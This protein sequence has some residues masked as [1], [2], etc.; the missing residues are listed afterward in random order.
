[1]QSKGNRC[2]LFTV[3]ILILGMGMNSFAQTTETAELQ[4]VIEQLEKQYNVRFSYVPKQLSGIAVLIPSNELDLA[5]AIKSL[6]QQTSLT[7]KKIDDR[8][9]SI[10]ENDPKAGSICGLLLNQWTGLPLEGAQIFVGENLYATISDA[11]GRFFIPKKFSS[12]IIQ[13][14]FLGYESMEIKGMGSNPECE[15][16]LMQ[17][18]IFDLNEVL[19]E[20]FLV[21]GIQRNLDGSTSLNAEN[22]GL[23]PDQNQ[24]DVL[25]MTQVLP[26]IE[27]S[28]E[29][30]STINM[31]GG[32]HDEN[33][34]LWEGARMYQNGHFFGLVSPFNPYLTSK[35]EVYKNGTP[36]HYG[37]SVSG[38][39]DIK[40][41]DQISKK[42]NGGL[43]INFLDAQG[44]IDISLSENFG[45]QL[46][47]RSSI[48]GL[49]E[50]PVYDNF[51]ERIFQD[52]E[53]T[54]AINSIS[55][56]SLVTRQSFNFFDIGAK[57]L[58]DASEKD[59]IRLSL[60]TI[61]NGL[62]FNER[63]T[64]L[65]RSTNSNLAQRSA[66]GSLSWQRK[67][68][69]KYTT[70][71]S[72]ATSYYLLESL[73]RDI[74]TTQEIYQENE[75]L[76][77]GIKLDFQ[78]KIEDQLE[79]KSGYHFT[80]TGI[81]NTQDVNL[82]RFRDL[83]KDVLRS[84]IL[85]GSLIWT[86]TDENTQITAGA[87]AN[88]FEK[89]K[90]AILEP[91]LHLYQELG[92]NFGIELGGEF[93]SQTTTQR[94]DF[95][96][97]FLGVEKRRWVI[98]NDAD[99]PIKQ[100]KQASVGLVY[101]KKDWFINA[102]T[103]YKKVTG[104]TS[105][106][107][108]F[109]NQFQ[110]INTTGSYEVRGLELIVNKWQNNFSGW[111]SYRY[112]TNKYIFGD[113]TPTIFPSNIDIEHTGTLAG[114]Y[115]LNNW[116][117]ALGFNWHS[118]K[119][120]TKPIT[121]DEIITEGDDVLINYSRPN[122]ERLPDYLRLDVS[123]EYRLTISDQTDLK[124]NL[125]LLNILDKDNILNIRYALEEQGSGIITLKEI[126]ERSLGFT[127]NLSAQLLF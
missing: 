67:W 101:K 123:T 7:F 108:G 39:I 25:Q 45:M 35:V 23:L 5:Q 104:I 1:M 3:F 4:L 29:T 127:P 113:L 120:Y 125:S 59:R 114:S 105:R 44:F 75:V 65:D 80:E 96:S 11:N 15:T 36:A 124:L 37:E 18:S 22:F 88:Y 84:H 116:K 42:I 47:V 55:N 115:D 31:R 110:F 82:P 56:A 33:L 34:I 51:T 98:S 74:F 121:G 17:A 50:T 68:S 97:D 81:S 77:L 53:I 90:K 112:N 102:E 66:I 79:L 26:G 46:S 93:K 58:W 41:N 117:F 54:N 109:Q 83:T 106:S 70:N 126:K 62:D 78:W 87:R 64:L 52:T 57:F 32:S 94:I 16:F 8:Y 122:E 103:F 73:N 118:G 20:L 48:N 14:Q 85:H 76:D 119:P 30:I 12:E 10:S 28:N 19:I 99:V 91:R 9:F 40:S 61:D 49:F 27:S 2:T 71:L 72:I 6:E 100:S 38:V 69:P 111:I 21:K 13:F 43:G 92:S 86:S 60:L 24:S 95:Q 63:L 89:F 107:Q